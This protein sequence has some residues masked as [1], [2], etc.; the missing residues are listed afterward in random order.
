MVRKILAVFA[1]VIVASICIWAIETLNHMMYPYPDGMKPNDMEGF[2][3]YIETLPF[4]GKFMVIVGYAVG[5]LVSGFIATK[6]SKD[7][8][9]TAAIICGIVFLVFTIYNMTVLPT[10]IWFW[11][12]GILVWILVLAGYKLALNKKQ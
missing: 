2:K 9:P 7:G 10:P 8:K 4:L 3:S 11:I 12:L 6:I 1:G 5:A